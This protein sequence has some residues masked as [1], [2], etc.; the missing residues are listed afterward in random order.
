MSI[1]YVPQYKST[2]LSAAGGIN[3]TVTTGII[4]TDI[5]G[6]DDTKPGIACFDWSN[7]LN[8]DVAEYISFTS[9]NSGTK[10]L[11]GVTRGAEGITA[12]SHDNGCTVAFIFS[13]SHV[14][15]S[16]DLLTGV[17]EGIKVKN[18]L[19]DINGKELFKVT[20]T[21][22]AV[23]EFTVTNSAASS[24]PIFEGTG[25]DTYVSPIFRGK[26]SF[27]KFSGIRD[28]STVG[29]TEIVD[30]R[31]GDRQK[32]TLDENLTITFSNAT[33]GQTL[34]LY[35]LQDGSGTNTIT[36]ADTI[37]WADATTPTWTT[38]AAKMNIAVIT[39]IGSAYYG[40]GNKF[41]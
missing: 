21:S 4:L 11:N 26:A 23:N 33:E 15:N 9:I 10:E 31:N 6:I 35:M 28:L 40:V 27:P 36:F 24:P 34:T 13:K 38:T 22:S 32:M 41:I 5:T 18:S 12:K 2:S 39:Y 20:A 17:T 8:T 7:P 19:Q 16:N 25:D 29:T 3:D 37:N 30:W 1:Y 14:N